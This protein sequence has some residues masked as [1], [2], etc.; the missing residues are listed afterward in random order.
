MAYPENQK[1]FYEDIELDDNGAM[2]VAVS[3]DPII[4]AQPAENAFEFFKAVV[5]IDGKL[6][7][8]IK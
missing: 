5:L 4:N 6:K 1:E 3:N 2:Q 7:V 8:K